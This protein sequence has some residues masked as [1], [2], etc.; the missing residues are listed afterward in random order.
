MLTNDEMVCQLGL[1]IAHYR[2]LRKM[3]QEELADAV[4]MSRAFLGH[5]EAP[6]MVVSF[7]LY[8]VFDIAR[9]LIIEPKLLFEFH[10]EGKDSAKLNRE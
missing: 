5:I 6:N 9:A 3:T 10:E 1:N 8:T 2:R 7:S 4:G